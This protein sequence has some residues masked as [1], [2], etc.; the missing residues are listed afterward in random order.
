MPVIPS[1][2]VRAWELLSVPESIE[3]SQWDVGVNEWTPERTLWATVIETA[4]VDALSQHSEV[5]VCWACDAWETIGIAAPTETFEAMCAVSGLVTD[6]VHRALHTRAKGN[7][8]HLPTRKRA[9][10]TPIKGIKRARELRVGFGR[11]KV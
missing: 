7:W 1:S 8:H 10:L 5:G 11:M 4:I 3:P 9:A 2:S 6:A